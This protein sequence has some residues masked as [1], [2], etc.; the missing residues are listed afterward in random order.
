MGTV[1]SVPFR[2]FHRKRFMLS[3]I[4][5]RASGKSMSAASLPNG[6]PRHPDRRNDLIPEMRVAI[7]PSGS[8][9]TDFS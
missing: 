1:L 9:I 6:F 7:S 4:G 5:Q 8:G 2:S 3:L